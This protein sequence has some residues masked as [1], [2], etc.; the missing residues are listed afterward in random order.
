[1]LRGPVRIIGGGNVAVDCALAASALGANRISV[2]YRRSRAEL[3][4]W[5]REVAHAFRLGVDFLFQ[6]Q[7]LAIERTGDL[8]YRLI[9][10][11]TTLGLPGEDGRREPIPLPSET[12]SL[13]TGTVIIAAGQNTKPF[14]EDLLERDLR[15]NIVVKETGRTNLANIYAGGDAALRGGTVAEA[16]GSGL[17][18]AHWIVKDLTGGIR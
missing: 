5:E 12:I 8:I 4:A 3:P 2:I 17:I 13:E 1:V 6:L 14:Q 9:C 18:A 7:P 16:V 11:R 15:G 10:R